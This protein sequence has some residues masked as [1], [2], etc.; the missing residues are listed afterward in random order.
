M[1][2]RT[3]GATG[4]FFATSFLTAFLSTLLAT[5]KQHCEGFDTPPK[6]EFLDRHDLHRPRQCGGSGAREVFLWLGDYAETILPKA[7]P[8]LRSTEDQECLDQIEAVRA[9]SFI[10]RLSSGQ[11]LG[12][13]EQGEAPVH[14]A[15]ELSALDKLMNTSWWHRVW[16]IQEAILPPKATVIVGWLQFPWNTLAAAAYNFFRHHALEC[17][18][19][20]VEFGVNLESFYQKVDAIQYY[21]TA[22]HEG[23]RLNLV[24]LLHRFRHRLC[25]D[26]RDK[27]FGLLGLVAGDSPYHA[28]RADYTLSTET[29]YREAFIHLLRSGGSLDILAR[30]EEVG[31]TLDLPTWM[32]DWTAKI[33][34]LEANTSRQVIGCLRIYNTS[35]ST[36]P[37]ILFPDLITTLNVKGLLF[38]EITT[39]AEP[40]R[41]VLE[42]N[43]ESEDA[44]IDYL[45]TLLDTKGRESQSYVG[46]GNRQHALSCLVTMDQIRVGSDNFL[47]G[48][49]RRATLE[50]H[51]KHQSTFALREIS[52]ALF[53][54]VIHFRVFI[55]KLGYFG[56]GPKNMRIGDTVHILLG[57][58]VPFV[59]RRTTQETAT[60]AQE[61]S[62][63]YVGNCYVQGIMDG[64]ALSNLAPSKLTWV[65][66]V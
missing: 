26:P 13:S 43:P 61:T 17:C 48:H 15:A 55:S 2:C 19:V 36:L 30:P 1:P 44:S 22:Y 51:G 23:T 63:E 12:F 9:L 64:E 35:L 53:S 7:R 49:Y 21:R 56:L 29:S 46:G 34:Q 27:I 33:D 18:F 16:T 62:Y 8:C 40:Y 60:P 41:N 54:F 28:L 57:G 38:N 59:L 11:H 66:L 50:D 20:R 42:K 3:H 14:L 52:K 31:R 10:E 39:L 45:E 24:D 37:E 58:S 5:L 32:P 6:P 4:Q 25:T 65:S 47:R